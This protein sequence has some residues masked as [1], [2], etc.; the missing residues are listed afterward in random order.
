[1][2]T[3]RVLMFP[4]ETK[5]K[6]MTEN[7]FVN[8]DWSRI[9]R[10]RAPEVAEFVR[11]FRHVTNAVLFQ[12]R[13]RREVIVLSK[14]ESA[15][16]FGSR[17]KGVMLDPIWHREDAALFENVPVFLVRFKCNRSIPFLSSHRQQFFRRERHER[18]VPQKPDVGVSAERRLLRQT[19]QLLFELLLKLLERICRAH[20]SAIQ[21]VWI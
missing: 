17:P 19:R 3:D 11:R 1:M 7:T 6:I 15:Q 4:G 21:F 13:G 18:D 20:A 10:C 2:A 8:G 14:T 5:L 16:I 12:A 9:H